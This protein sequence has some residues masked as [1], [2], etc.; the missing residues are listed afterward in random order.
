MLLFALLTLSVVTAS[1]GFA[2]ALLGPAAGVAPSASG[3]P[4]AKASTAKP[5]GSS[6]EAVLDS[7]EDDDLSA[8]AVASA[9]LE[10]RKATAKHTT[11]VRQANGIA[12]AWA[13]LARGPPSA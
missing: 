9:H 10:I 13:H 7:L 11:E 12:W 6:I 4:L 2:P 3:H 8:G 1:S 5:A